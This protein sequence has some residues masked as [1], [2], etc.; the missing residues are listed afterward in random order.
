MLL[1][2]FKKVISLLLNCSDMQKKCDEVIQPYIFDKHGELITLLL[3]EIYNE[4]SVNYIL[5]EWLC[6]NKSPI[7]FTS[8][9]GV[10]VEVPI[11]TVKELWQAMETYGVKSKE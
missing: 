1:K 6:G 5:N 4:H 2:D 7:L 10:S 9:N 3:K 11:N 8:N